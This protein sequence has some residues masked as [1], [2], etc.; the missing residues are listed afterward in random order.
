MRRS[1]VMIL[2]VSLLHGCAA[3]MAM[4]GQNGPDLNVVQRQETRDDIE[5]MLGSPVKRLRRSDGKMVDLYIAEARTEPSPS[6][7]VGHATVDLF[8]FG[9]WEFVGGPME[10]YSGRRQRVVVEYDDNDRVVSMSRRPPPPWRP[11]SAGQQSASRDWNQAVAAPSLAP[12]VR[13]DPWSCS[14]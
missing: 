11:V 12:R 3:N 9:L 14:T 8:T 10:A 5:R 1:I 2:L 7:A 4:Q 13:L 6:R